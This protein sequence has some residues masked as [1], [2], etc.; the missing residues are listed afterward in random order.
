MPYSAEDSK[1][2]NAGCFFSGFGGYEAPS[3]SYG[4]YFYAPPDR[5]PYVA[6]IQHPYTGSHLCVGTLVSE[7]WVLTHASCLDTKRYTTAVRNPY[8]ALG[9][10]SIIGPFKE[11]HK[12]DIVK[13]HPRYSGYTTS[14][15]D[16]VLLRLAEPSKL[17]PLITMH[18][19]SPPLLEGLE[20]RA[21]GWSRLET[22]GPHSKKL[23]EIT[24]A[25]FTVK[26]ITQS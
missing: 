11:L 23:L 20:T 5:Y 9:G 18:S 22:G 21:I 14:P 3:I 13:F 16:V 1:G 26:F 4:D 25:F 17:R 6:S 2:H 15:Y 7:R 8:V 19:G 12:I 10:E 24:G